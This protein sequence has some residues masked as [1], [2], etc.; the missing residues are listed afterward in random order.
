MK[1]KTKKKINFGGRSGIYG[2][3]QSIASNP[4]IA[5]SQASNMVGM[6]LTPEAIE[7][8]P[9]PIYQRNH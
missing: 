7:T 1:N 5:Y 2:A 3:I 4:A 6:G 9:S 8:Y